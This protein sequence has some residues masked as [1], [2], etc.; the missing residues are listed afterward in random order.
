MNKFKRII[1]IYIFINMLYSFNYC[2]NTNINDDGVDD[3]TIV[4]QH[5]Y[6][7]LMFG[8]YTAKYI[9]CGFTE[10]EYFGDPLWALYFLATP[11]GHVDDPFS[12]NLLSLFISQSSTTYFYKKDM[13]YCAKSILAVPCQ[14]NFSDL[15]KSL[16]TAVIKDCQGGKADFWKSGHGNW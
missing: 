14:A 8:S 15:S 9:S 1:N 11:M 3:S 5:E 12:G 16:Q 13:N 7:A 6:Y 10:K 4:A 2:N